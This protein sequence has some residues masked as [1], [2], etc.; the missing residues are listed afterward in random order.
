MSSIKEDKTA[1][2]AKVKTIVFNDSFRT[3]R[4]F[5]CMRSIQAYP[6]N[7]TEASFA[8]CV[9]M[10]HCDLILI[11]AYCLNSVLVVKSQKGNMTSVANDTTHICPFNYGAGE[12]S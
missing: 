7:T 4:A 1:V 11:F 8:R 2:A 12:D 6:L 10:G 3:P 5:S 9:Y